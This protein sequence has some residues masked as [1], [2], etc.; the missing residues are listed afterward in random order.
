MPS[1]A[2]LLIVLLAAL[3]VATPAA[4]LPNFTGDYDPA[5]RVTVVLV[6]DDTLLWTPPALAARELAETSYRVYGVTSEGKYVPL[7]DQPPL[8][9]R[10]TVPAGFSNY[11]VSLVKGSV[12][13][14]VTF[15]CLHLYG[16]PPVIVNNCGP[17]PPQLADIRM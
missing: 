10:T 4:G 1:K 3:A 16:I 15:K 9:F 14:S 13:G 6:D 12:E 5:R 11:G 17:I 8:S 2:A 7:G